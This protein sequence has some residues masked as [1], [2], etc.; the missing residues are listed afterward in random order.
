MEGDLGIGLQSDE[1]Y[2]DIE[3]PATATQKSLSAQMVANGLIQSNAYSLWLNDLQASTGNILFG[4]VDV[5]HY[6]PP[7]HTLPI[8]R[9]LN[10]SSFSYITLTDVNFGS[11]IIAKHQAISASLESSSSLTYLP[12]DITDAIFQEVGA[13]YDPIIGYPIVPCSQGSNENT[14]NFTFSSLTIAI[15]MTELVVPLTSTETGNALTFPDGRDACAFG[16]SPAQGGR[17]TLGATF[18]RSVYIVFDLSNNEISMAQTIF[19]A[20]GTNLLEIGTGRAAVPGA[21]LVQNIAMATP[22][23]ADRALLTS[24]TP[25]EPGLKGTAT[26]TAGGA[27]KTASLM[28]IAAMVFVAGAGAFLTGT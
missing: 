4:G 28:N 22:T 5:A 11:I 1:G 19:N 2:V 20:T 18:M 25:T 16:I 6:H 27:E 8:Q 12:D 26:S 3:R 14:L 21:T 24:A 13:I 17:V 10:G 7:L 15:P 23:A 9:D